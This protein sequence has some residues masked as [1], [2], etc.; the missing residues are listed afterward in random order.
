M[1]NL[2]ENLLPSASAEQA[3]ANRK[4]THVQSL[5]FIYKCKLRLSC[6]SRFVPEPMQPPPCASI[7][8]AHSPLTA[9]HGPHCGSIHVLCAVVIYITCSVHV[10]S[11]RHSGHCT[12]GSRLRQHTCP[13]ATTVT[14]TAACAITT[15]LHCCSVL[16]LRTEQIRAEAHAITHSSYSRSMSV[17]GSL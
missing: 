2:L 5:A 4:Q 9:A 11:S 3:T 13:I 8:C 14:V 1:L 7:A 16:L 17:W 10:E 6:A 12:I 15:R